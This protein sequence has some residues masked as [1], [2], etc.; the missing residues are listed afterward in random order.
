MCSIAQRSAHFLFVCAQCWYYFLFCLGSAGARHS[1]HCGFFTS[2]RSMQ[3]AW[4]RWKHGSVLN[5]SSSC[6]SSKHT[7]HSALS[8]TSA[9]ERF[10][11]AAMLLGLNT[12]TGTWLIWWLTTLRL[13]GCSSGA[14]E[15]CRAAG[16]VGRAGYVVR[17][18]PSSIGTTAA[19]ERWL[20]NKIRLSLFKIRWCRDGRSKQ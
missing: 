17:S 8:S 19:P 16:L 2:Q 15:L 20:C 3:Q 9:F 18:S 7:Q 14:K 10:C 5:V 13:A 11:S 12:K 1:G 4:K 6:S